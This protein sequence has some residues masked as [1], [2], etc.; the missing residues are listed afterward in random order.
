MNAPLKPAGRV[1]DGMQ[2]ANWSREIFEQ[3]RGGGVCA[4]HV[5]VA[6]HENFRDTVELLMRWHERLRVHDDLIAFAG[7]GAEINSVIASGRTAILF[8]AQNPSPIEADIR[9]VE[10]LYQLGIRF[11]QLSYNNQSLLCTGWTERTD[12]GLTN[13]GREVINEMNRVGMLVDMSHSAERSTLEAIEYSSRP[14][15]VSH[16]NPSCW[17]ATERNKSKTALKALAA[18]GGHVGLSLYPGHLKDGSATTLDSFARMA[19]SLADTI[20]VEHIGIGSDLCQN[21]PPEVLAWMRQGLWR[22]AAPEEKRELSF[23][24]QPSWFR[25]NLDFPKVRA[26]LVAVGF[27]ETDV[28]RIMWKN[29]YDFLAAALTPQAISPVPATTKNTRSQARAS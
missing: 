9:L 29:W 28:E 11:M 24:D 1:I 22:H 21:Q 20:G 26:G 6:Y 14:I 13:M 7:S 4:V 3:M 17:M 2:F 18:A 25:S 23:P 15:V 27:S 19:L 8:G 10:V 5:T 16:A 12:S